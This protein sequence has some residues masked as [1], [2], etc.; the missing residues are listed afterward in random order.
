[1]VAMTASRRTSRAL[2]ATLASAVLGLTA[3]SNGAE[4]GDEGAGS[5]ASGN[6]FT[7]AGIVFDAPAGWEELDP[8]DA[9]VSGDGAGDIAEGLGMTP[10]Q[11]QE[12]VSQVDLF[13]V[14]GTGPKENFLDNIN[15]LEQ[16]GQL[17]A[18]DD[19]EQEF[20]GLGASVLDVTREETDAGEVTA[21][22]YELD[23]S[24]TTVHGASYL[25]ARD[26]QVVTITVSTSDRART[27]EIGE[28]VL[29]TLAEAG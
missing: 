9:E 10:E 6:E 2:V 15:V 12:A 16:Q 17:P 13:V 14:D 29:G 22:S 23:A 20:T 24:G 25:L 28:Q 7:A 26:E 19:I 5:A 18:D 1:M 4:G 3:C 21:V 8:D 27:A 11:L